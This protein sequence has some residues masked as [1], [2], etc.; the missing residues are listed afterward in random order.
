MRACNT[1][2][3]GDVSGQLRLAT[4]ISSRQYHAELI[5]FD[6]SVLR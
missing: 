4:E 3:P 6:D 2:L 1:A 5:K